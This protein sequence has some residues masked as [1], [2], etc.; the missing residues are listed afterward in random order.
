M[1]AD[2]FAKW[3]INQGHKIYRT[4]TSYWYD[5][6]PHVLQAFPYHWLITPD[7]EEIDALMIR[8]RILALRYSSPP[9]SPEGKLSYHI[10][11]N[12]YY[13][14]QTLGQK[15]RNGV[16]RGLE[17]FNIE[18]ITFE[19]LANEGWI[20]QKDTLVRQNRTQS[21]SQKQW[22]CLCNS[23]KELP[24]FH[25]FGAVSGGELAGALIVCRINDIYSVPYAMSLSR[26]LKYHVNNALFFTTCCQLLKKENVNGIFLTVQSLD[27]PAQLDDFKLRMGFIPKMVRQNV[28]I[29]PYLRPLITPAVHSFN[30]RLLNRYPSNPFLAKTEG[31]LRFHL[32]GK[33]PVGEQNIPDC[34]KDQIQI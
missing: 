23:A 13:D 33:K 7:Q 10:L 31:M 30:R 2:V 29:H 5:A 32:E 8:R 6:G 27:A 25:A 12:K 16:K 15:A 20:L 19:R 24:G 28:I 3:L 34:V 4:K 18:E 22:E 11:L 1:N 21:M 26:S 14:L 9:D 17:H